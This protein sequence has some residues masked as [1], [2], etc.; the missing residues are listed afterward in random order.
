MHRVDRFMI[1][2]K[3]VKLLA[4]GKLTDRFR[5]ITQKIKTN[6][7]FFWVERGIPGFGKADFRLLVQGKGDINLIYDSLKGGYHTK[8]I[9][10]K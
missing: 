5:N 7:N 2:N 1:A 4:A 3:N 10:L 8:V 6:K 9:S